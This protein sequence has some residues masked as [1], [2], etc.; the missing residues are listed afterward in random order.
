M[1]FFTVE[2]IET[3]VYDTYADG[4]YTVE[5]LHMEKKSSFY[6]G[7]YIEIH[8]QFMDS[9]YEGKV[10]ITKYLINHENPKNKH[11]A[12]QNISRLAVNIANLKPGEDLEPEHIIGK[13]TKIL[14]RNDVSAR[15]NKFSK[16]I[17]E[18][19]ANKNKEKIDDKGEPIGIAGSGMQP[20]N[21][22]LPSDALNDKVPF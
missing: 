21:T 22:T 5:I 4:E 2:E 12:R 19:L 17:R 6:D 3:P 10:W 9:E 1:T 13:T 20:L 18:E 7:V 16:I 8:R 14:I 11:A 15:G